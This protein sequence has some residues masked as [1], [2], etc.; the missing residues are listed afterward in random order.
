M[1]FFKHLTKGN[2]WSFLLFYIHCQTLLRTQ[3]SALVNWL[4]K[5]LEN[6]IVGIRDSIPCLKYSLSYF[7]IVEAC[8][9]P[10]I[11][12]VLHAN[13]KHLL[14][15]FFIDV[16]R[17]WGVLGGLSLMTKAAVICS[18]HEERLLQS[19]LMNLSQ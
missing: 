16:P 7:C 5:L 3:F 10:S 9:N 19:F 13:A 6:S 4:L 8:H 11:F 2:L 17:W 14:S 1:S 18:W 15:S 12:F